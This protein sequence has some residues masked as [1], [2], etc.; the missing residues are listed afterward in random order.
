[1]GTAVA[2]MTKSRYKTLLEASKGDNELQALK[3]LRDIIAD[4][5]DNTHQAR[6]ISS[7]SRQY[8]FVLQRISELDGRSKQNRE[9]RGRPTNDETDLE[10]VMRV[11]KIVPDD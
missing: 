4:T 1:M 8:T 5:I 6:D 3:K 7:L 2:G 9:K 10:S 11:M